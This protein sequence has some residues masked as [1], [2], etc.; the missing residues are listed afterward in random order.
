MIGEGAGF[1]DG[2]LGK[3]GEKVTG[4]V[5][6]PGRASRARASAVGD[7]GDGAATPAA[8]ALQPSRAAGR[9]PCGRARRQ[10]SLPVAKHEVPSPR[11]R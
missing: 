7:D 3:G 6:R 11:D 8:R 5:A 10:R 2:S 4:S 9:S 1:R